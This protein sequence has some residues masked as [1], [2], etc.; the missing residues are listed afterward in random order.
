MFQLAMD[1]ASE[2]I[3]CNAV[4]PTWVQ[5]PLLDVELQKN[6]QV[7]AE[8]AAVVPIKRAAKCEE[9]SDA[10]AFLCSPAA[11]YIN[12]TS[13]VIDSAVTTTIRLH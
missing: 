8:I 5:T 12:G 13:L 9:V 11:S 10:I 1:H 3:R 4:C 7:Q 6:P 2:G